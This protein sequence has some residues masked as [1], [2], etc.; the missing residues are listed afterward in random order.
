[1]PASERK[2]IFIFPTTFYKRLTTEFTADA[3]KWGESK[4]EIQHSRVA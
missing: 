4:T 3:P 1:M 2:R